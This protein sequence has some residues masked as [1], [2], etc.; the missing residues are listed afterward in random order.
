MK[1]FCNLCNKEYKSYQS[2]WNH[3]H[4]FHSDDILINTKNET[5]KAHKSEKYITEKEPIRTEKEPIRTGIIENITKKEPD[6]TDIKCE[7]CN[8]IFTF[9]SALYRHK[10]LR[11]KVKHQLSLNNDTINMLKKENNTFKEEIKELRDQLLD[12]MNKTCKV[13]PKQ[14]LKIN[15][16]LNQNM[17]NSL[18]GVINSNNKIYNIVSLGNENLLQTL[19]QKEQ[20]NILNKKTKCLDYLIKYVHFNDKYPQFKNI[21]ITNQNNNIAYKYDSSENKFMATTKEQ[22]LDI[23]IDCRMEDIDIFLENNNDLIDVSL[24]E[25]VERFVNKIDIDENFKNT[26][27]TDI[28]LMLY[29][30]KDK[31]NINSKIESDNIITL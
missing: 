10:N 9:N 3:K 2:L 7:F 18:N 26:K 28:K 17:N 19:T 8:T 13:H 23:L 16:Q 22:L 5:I 6:I 4:K 15:K 27:K 21:C 24:K 11:C 20:L 31:T 12:I 29:N 25:A 14:M 30:C 1:Y